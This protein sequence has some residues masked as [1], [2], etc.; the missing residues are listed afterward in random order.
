MIFI[1]YVNMY[2]IDGDVCSMDIELINVRVII[3]NT[4]G[5]MYYCFITLFY[6]I[7]RICI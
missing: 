7:E 2:E 3:I 6:Y 4:T 5:Y 1:N